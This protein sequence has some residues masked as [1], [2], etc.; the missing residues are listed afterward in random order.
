M[1]KDRANG[2]RGKKWKILYDVLMGFALIVPPR[3]GWSDG[4]PIIRGQFSF[5][6]FTVKKKFTKTVV[7]F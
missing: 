1:F 7:L 6:I 3:A 4:M 5:M 2:G